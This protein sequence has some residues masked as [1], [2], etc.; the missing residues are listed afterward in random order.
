L[1]A[2][3]NPLTVLRATRDVPGLL[4]IESFDH[5]LEPLQF[6]LE[7]VEALGYLQGFEQP[8]QTLLQDRQVC[9][10]NGLQRVTWHVHVGDFPACLA[11]SASELIP[12]PHAILYDAYSPASNPAM[13]TAPV[14]A[15]LYRRLDPQRPCAMATYSRST[16]LRT[17]LL[18]AGFHVGAGHATG[19]KEET[20]IAAN[21]PALIAEPLDRRW[22]ARARRST[23]AE[24]LWTPEYRQA[25]IAPATWDQLRNH[26]QFNRTD[27][28]AP[29]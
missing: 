7:H 12:K 27:T 14:F 11:S 13:W 29:E 18:L 3:A 10:P 15:R 17:T 19:E 9:F 6:A 23:S 2:A 24:P 26:P 8:L 22:L 1:G 16:L 5:T 4:C 25:R 21:T 28:V 20:T